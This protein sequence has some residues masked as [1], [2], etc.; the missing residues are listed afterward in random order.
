MISSLLKETQSRTNTA[1]PSSKES[2]WINKEI[3][4]QWLSRLIQKI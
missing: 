2:I 4:K 1:S 3:V